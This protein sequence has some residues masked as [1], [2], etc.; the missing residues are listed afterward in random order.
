MSHTPGEWIAKY[1]DRVALS[2]DLNGTRSVAHV[3]DP[4][5]YGIGGTQEDNRH[6]IASAPDLTV[7]SVQS[8]NRLAGRSREPF[9]P[10]NFA[11]INADSR[12]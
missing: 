11:I 5:A 12:R 7:A 6:F 2:D 10:I 8:V 4:D 3:Y 9:G 1:G